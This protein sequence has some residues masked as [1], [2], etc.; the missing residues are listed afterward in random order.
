MGLGAGYVFGAVLK[1]IVAEF[2]W[3][4]AAFS[5]S[6]IPL[7]AAM[8]LS[9]PLVGTLTERAGARRVLSG[10]ALLLGASLWL[11]SR[12]TSLW[13]FYATSVLFGVALTGLGDV[14]VG[15]VAARWVTAQRGLALAFVYVGSNAGGA[16]VPV[17][18]QSIA[19]ASSWRD[20]LEWVGL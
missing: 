13:E 3:S 16:A 5:A 12:M 18:A 2:E 17:V 14:A 7:L 15:A 20:A 8:A 4:R 1:N 19:A 9:A 6:G 10:A 11:F